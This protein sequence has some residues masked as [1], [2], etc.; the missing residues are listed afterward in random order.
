MPKQR[1]YRAEYEAR[2]RR[3]AERGLSVSQARGHPSAKKLEKSIS[4]IKRE[5]KMRNISVNQVPSI[6][7][8]RPVAKQS[9]FNQLDV[10]D[11]NALRRNIELLPSRATVWIVARGRW[12]VSPLSVRLPNET[13]WRTIMSNRTKSMALR[14]LDDMAANWGH[15]TEQYTLRWS[16]Y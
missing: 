3:A 16:K 4:H 7:L 15:L 2:L 9:A 14:Q 1:D 11:V 10:A 6:R 12:E 5:A 8:G 13:S